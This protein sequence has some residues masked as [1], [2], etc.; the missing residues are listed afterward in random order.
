MTSTYRH[1]AVVQPG[2]V[3]EVREPSL[4]EGRIVGVTVEVAEPDGE[5]RSFMRFFGAGRGSFAT[6]EEVDAFI[7]AERDAWERQTGC[8]G[9]PFTSMRTS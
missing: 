6:P 2:G 5:P 4:P 9:L 3:V 8:M 7:N 1:T